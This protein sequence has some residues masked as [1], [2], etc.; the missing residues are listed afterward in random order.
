[1]NAST[2]KI[3]G[4]WTDT[5]GKKYSFEFKLAENVDA[6]LSLKF[7]NEDEITD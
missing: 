3:G 1:M 7:E 5:D 2:S 6:D 4:S